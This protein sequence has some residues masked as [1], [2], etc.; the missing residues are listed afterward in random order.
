MVLSAKKKNIVKK[1]VKKTVKSSVGSKRAKKILKKAIKKNV[2]K[3]VVKKALKKTV[4]KVIKK[5]AKKASKKTVKKEVKKTAKKVSKSSVKLAKKITK[6]EK[7]ASLL[8][9]AAKLEKELFA[10]V[11]V[12]YRARIKKLVNYCKAQGY[13]TSDVLSDG[14]L[15]EECDDNA[16]TWVCIENIL[17]HNCIDLVEEGGVLQEVEIIN[18]SKFLDSSNPSNY[19][20]IQMYLRD[21]GKYKLLTAQEE[22]ELSEKIKKYFSVINKKSKKNITPSEK[23]RIIQEGIEAR[24]KLATS[25]LRLVI[26]IA[27]NYS[28]RTRDLSLL[29]LAHE[30]TKGLYKAVDKFDS[31]RG[32]KF[33]TYATWWIKQAVVRGIADKSRTIRVPVHMSETTQRYEKANVHLEQALGRPPTI[34][35]LAS[36]LGVEP[37]R[38]HMIRR[39]SQDVIQLDKPIGDDAEGG[40]KIVDT[41]EDEVSDTPEVS[42]AREILKEQIQEVLG[43][44]SS[45]ER[46]VI[47]LRHGMKE[48]RVQYTLEQIGKKLG[49]TRERIRQIE[50]KALERLSA[51][52]TL[53]KLESY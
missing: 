39:I 43:E 6:E 37:E 49:V 20:S 10:D 48:D 16:D 22:V 52:K 41:I 29:D 40:T 3:K 17:R 13:V 27:K 36:E 51:N 53:K 5:T 28:N 11:P 46:H 15:L 44:L 24:D 19:D 14:L 8:I 2:S 23:K 35:E 32:F 30:G 38:I 9:D 42:A 18:N 45:R 21:I 7:K 4:K 33:S 12:K 47:E 25:N 31:S 34:Q 26:S 1:A 50:A